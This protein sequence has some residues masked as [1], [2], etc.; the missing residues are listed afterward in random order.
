MMIHL[1]PEAQW[2]VYPVVEGA[3]LPGYP[4]CCCCCLPVDAGFG[5]S[6]D[7]PNTSCIER[8]THRHSHLL[9]FAG[10]LVRRFSGSPV[11]R[12]SGTGS[13]ERPR[14]C[15]LTVRPPG[16]VQRHSTPVSVMRM[17]SVISMPPSSSHIAGMKW[18]VMPACSRVRSPRRNDMVRSPQ[19]GG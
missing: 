4:V 11:L 8:L 6:S 10:S 1:L 13:R 19:S 14:R 2:S 15:Y 5:A 3:C 18:K 7:T 17:G 9:S 12:F 16:V